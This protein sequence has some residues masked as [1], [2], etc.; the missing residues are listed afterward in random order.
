MR[1]V[2]LLSGAARSAP[3]QAELLARAGV[4]YLR[5]IDRDYVELANLQRQLLYDEQAA[6]EVCPKAIAA[7]R[8]LKAIN[9]G[10]EIE[11]RVADLTPGNI[12]DLLGGVSPDHGRHRQLRNALPRQ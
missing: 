2:W 5:V 12:E 8:R 4:G 7:A 3:V 10:I 6:R 1:P 9:S 11:P